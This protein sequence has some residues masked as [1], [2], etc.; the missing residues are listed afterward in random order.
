M[1][2][3]VYNAVAAILNADDTLTEEEKARVLDA[4]RGPDAGE[5]PK[6]E[7]PTLLSLPEV[8][9]VLK[10]HPTTVRRMVRA[11]R[12]RRL[13]FTRHPRFLL[14]DVE[15]L[16]GIRGEGRRGRRPRSSCGE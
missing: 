7:A 1:K 3:A 2:P 13:G 11:G 4:C 16:A 14:E 8:A 10:V 5:R 12:L 9:A 6:G 15:R